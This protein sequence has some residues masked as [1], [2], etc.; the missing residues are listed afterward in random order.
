MPTQQ[1]D[2]IHALAELQRIDWKFEPTTDDE[3]RCKCP[4]HD[5][6]SP[7]A[8]LNVK[9]NV[10]KCHAAGCGQAGDIVAFLAFA[11]KTDRR[12]VLADLSKRYDLSVVKHVN[13][14]TLEKY[15]D[16]IWGSG[17][18]LDELHERGI[19]DVMIRKAR[20]GFHDGRIMIP[21]Y[22]E[23][24]R[25]INVRKYLP[26]APG[27]EKMRNTV[28]YTA[29]AVYMPNQLKYDTVWICGGE[30]KALAAAHYLN[31]K[32]IG[33]VAI[34]GG[35]GT[36]NEKFTP[37]FRGK[38]VYVCFDIDAAGRA[39]SRKVAAYL[40]YEAASVHI[41]RLP[42][43]PDKFPTGDLN[44]FIGREGARSKELLQV[45]ET[46][47]HFQ[48]ETQE[49]ETLEVV[50]VKLADATNFANMGKRLECSGLVSAIDTTPYLVAK[51][52]GVNCTKDQPGCPY[53]PIRPL[54]PDEE[55]GYV[56][57]TVNSASAGLL[58]M[59]ATPK[60]HQREAVREALGIPTCK[61]ATFSVRT[62][63]NVF[64]ARLT[65]ELTIDTDNRDHTVQPAFIIDHDADL[66]VPYRFGGRLFPHPK[67][68]QAV[69]VMD[70]LDS[71]EDTLASFKPSNEEMGE[72]TKFSPMRWTVDSLDAQLDM[73][74]ADLE[75]NVTRI[76]KRRD[77]HLLLDLAWHSALYFEFDG[78][79]Q[80]GWVNT[81]VIG[82]SSQGK[83]ETSSQLLKHYGLGARHDCKNAS[84]AG[85][86]GG[87]QQMG[88]NRW[89][90]TWG[91][92]PINDRRLVLMEE[93]K[94]A[95]EEVI[96]R[97][98]DMRTSGVAELSKIERRRSHARTRLVMI[99]NPRSDRT[100]PS[101]NFGI[102]AIKEL[103]GALE[104][105]RRFDL[106][107]IVSSTQIDPAELN[108]LSTT[109]PSVEPTFT[110]ELCKRL[111]LWAW[112]RQPN[113]IKF[114]SAAI[115]RCLTAS[116]TLCNT[117]SESMPLVDRGTM[118]FKVA[119]LA[120]ALAALTYSHQEDS[121]LVRICHVEYIEKFLL[122]L[123]SAPVFGYLDFS[124]AQDYQHKVIDPDTV[125][126]QIRASKYPRDFVEHLLHADR[127][128]LDDIGD[129]C[130]LDQ[131]ESRK[132][133]S[134]LVRKHAL[135]RKDRSTYVKTSEFIVLLKALKDEG[136]EESSVPIEGSEF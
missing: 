65:P 77:L 23:Q 61:A 117:F 113:Q 116:T 50:S 124:K 3:V 24:Q 6:Q 133:I 63:Y 119:R 56:Q 32:S 73:L 103:I 62:H 71:A 97:L 87:L 53:C 59:V 98:T 83:S 81:L 105:I 69:L 82:D 47:E 91:V 135:F 134:F 86:L 129:W 57:L 132:I 55:T 127:I 33:A 110:S 12:T 78:Q 102:E 68:Q 28:G 2:R 96:A 48:I 17:T 120:V 64:D 100:M 14:A 29:T 31:R 76:Y 26:G 41:V 121:I 16:A 107:I 22:D 130:E 44:D 108:K 93:I 39:A 66:N 80:K 99:S 19:T 15:H 104:D 75:A 37:S 115:D 9:K 49:P 8:Q 27:A 72:L 88:N 45:A 35:E 42:L 126:A 74:Y 25:A 7:S 136:L 46:A 112:T 13:P 70:K 92:I 40:A 67:T 95:S 111:I 52:V 125:K 60:R 1:L 89:F 128:S 109:R 11:L 10:W 30:L 79:Q 18:F 101:Y 43:D 131:P 85:L 106:A 118:R 123:Y 21:I 90:V 34:T 36:W 122:E 54:D 4:A 5:D 51:D 84:V 20:L 58:D 38:H 94:G 114:E